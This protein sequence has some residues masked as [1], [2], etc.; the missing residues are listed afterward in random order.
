MVKI[1]T[2]Y[3]NPKKK[4]EDAAPLE[5]VD[6]NKLKIPESSR[7]IVRNMLAPLKSF[8]ETSKATAAA[9]SPTG[10]T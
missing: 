9:P 3:I 5:I 8:V 6:V 4:V 2:N 10:T 1:I 7:D